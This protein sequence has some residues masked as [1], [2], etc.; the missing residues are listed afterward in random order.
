MLESGIYS[1]I[2]LYKYIVLGVL[3]PVLFAVFKYWRRSHMKVNCWFCGLNNFILKKCQDGWICKYCEQYNGFKP[4]GDYNRDIPAQ[5][6]SS[7][8]GGVSF[9][10]SPKPYAT[11]SNGLCDDC[12]RNQEMK[13]AQLASFQPINPNNFDQ[14]IENFSYHLERAY[15][16]CRTCE[17]VLEDTLSRKKTHILDMNLQL[18][19]KMIQNGR[20]QKHKQLFRKSIA[21]TSTYINITIALAIAAFTV[22]TF[23]TDHILFKAMNFESSRNQ[24]NPKSYPTTPRSFLL[25]S[26]PICL[27][28]EIT[29]P[30][31]PPYFSKILETNLGLYLSLVGTHVVPLCI[32]G[33]TLKGLSS[34]HT[35]FRPSAVLWLAFAGT[36]F[37]HELKSEAQ[38]IEISQSFQVIV[39]LL[40][41]AFSWCEMN[42]CGLK[43]SPLK[44][45][46][47]VSPKPH[48]SKPEIISPVVQAQTRAAQLYAQPPSPR[49]PQTS[50][51]KTIEKKQECTILESPSYL[52][53]PSRS[54]SVMSL[55]RTL[56]SVSVAENSLLSPAEDIQSV[57]SQ[58]DNRSDASVDSA[59]SNPDSITLDGADSCYGSQPSVSSKKKNSQNG[60]VH[61]LIETLSIGSARNR[62]TVRA[63]SEF[64]TRTYTPEKKR[65][66]LLC[67]PKLTNIMNESRRSG[68]WK[69]TSHNS[70]LNSSVMSES[71][72]IFNNSFSRPVSP[73]GSVHS[74]S[75][76][77]SGVELA[78]SY[79]SPSSFQP[80]TPQWN[81]SAPQSLLSVCVPQ[82]PLSS[83]AGFRTMAPHVT[84]SPIAQMIYTP[85]GVYHQ[86]MNQFGNPVYG[87]YIKSKKQT[88]EQ[89][90]T[91][92]GPSSPI[93]H[94]HQAHVEKNAKVWQKWHEWYLKN[95]KRDYCKSC[96]ESM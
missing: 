54:A 90:Y 80:I 9:C 19:G 52:S 3:L 96:A 14:E 91:K 21:W 40:I 87:T 69:N 75:T 65:A 17:S 27:N 55:N 72:D 10:T 7:Q 63:S 12:N 68:I 81:S 30:S 77:Q 51:L 83:N 11:P 5:W 59:F 28:E 16:L 58:E 1:T 4:D 73:S 47:S 92:S 42:S 31:S 35:G 22:S 24:I 34:W 45:L 89:P 46:K 93:H 95:F 36:V 79:S 41:V 20:L 74:Q 84:T 26:H 85:Y 53:L 39:S 48:L 38:Y 44:R 32:I 66:S 67:P 49:L 13:V 94:H 71:G 25:Q 88:Y 82:N 56:A 78:R 57:L 62:Q 33:L 37:F 23:S 61:S 8:N 86:M 60:D 64:K 18:T 6:D 70:L 15:K 2:M 29:A 76:V 50:L 43:P